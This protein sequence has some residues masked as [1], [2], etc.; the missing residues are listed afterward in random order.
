[1]STNPSF[2]DRISETA[3]L[4]SVLPKTL[5]EDLNKAGI[6]SDSTGESLL[7]ASTTTVEDLVGIL[8]AG[9][10]NSVPNLKLKAAA[11]VLKGNSLTKTTTPNDNKMPVVQADADQKT[12]V[13]VLKEQRPIAN[14]SDRDLLERYSKDREHQVEQELNRR[15]K[16]QNFIVLVDGKFFEPGKEEIEIDVS[17]DLLK[18]ARKRTNPSMIPHGDKVVQVYKITELNIED[19]LVELCPICGELLFR[20]YCEKCLSNF[21]GVGDEERA[22]VKL[23]ADSENFSSESRADRRDVVVSAKKGLEDLKKTWP[24]VWK[25]FDKL[26]LLLR[27]PKLRLL[28]SRPSTTVADPFFQDG[29]R[30]FGHKKY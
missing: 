21:V 7:N 18:S 6:S 8:E 22:Y 4:L 12:L 20:G 11:S 29:N 10:A 5:T 19:R 15:A 27:L 17:L 3:E 2:T 26:K 28:Q 9:C 23:I 30:A 24:S 14:W 13:E 16:Q 25:E 1:M